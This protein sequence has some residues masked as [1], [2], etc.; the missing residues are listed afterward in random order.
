MRGDS[1]AFTPDD[2]RVGTKALTVNLKCSIGKVKI[3]YN[4][5]K[6]QKK[7]VSSLKEWNRNAIIETPEKRTFLISNN[8]SVSSEDLNKFQLGVFF[9][10][11]RS[12]ASD[13]R[14][15]MR[16]GGGGRAAALA[17]ALSSRELRLLDIAHWIKVQEALGRE[18]D[19]ALKH[20]NS[21]RFAAN[22]LLPSLS[23]L[24]TSTHPTLH[25]VVTKN[26]KILD[27]RM[28]SEGE[29]S[30]LAL[31][32][33]LAMRLSLAYPELDDP[34]RDGSAIVLIDELDLH[35]H[36]QWQRSVVE[37]L[38][39]TFKKC[40]F[41]ATTHSPQIVASVKPEQVILM[42]DNGIIKQERT[43]GMDTNWILRHLMETTERPLDSDRIVKG[44]EDYI[45]R[46]NFQ[47]ARAMIAKAIKSGYDLPEWS[48]LDARMA[49]LEILS[50]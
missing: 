29:R 44:V 17:E 35:L 40:Q 47:K 30:L 5:H 20:L 3:D 39:K 2:I 19:K 8:A 22:R 6:P 24:S 36:P 26:R 32:L 37:Q 38:T 16:K 43:L 11:R 14:T 25:L 41:I 50:K 13:A 12:L 45:H 42:T 10:V 9:S 31:A 7:I 18:S 49:R 33:D 48:I 46:N 15:S 1:L 4:V 23:T 34:V 27:V 21:M 28:L